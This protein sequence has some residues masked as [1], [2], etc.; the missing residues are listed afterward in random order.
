MES[1]KVVAKFLGET[2]GVTKDCLIH[3]TDTIDVTIL[4]LGKVIKIW[5]S[6]PEE[7]L[8]EETCKEIQAFM[9]AGKI[10]E[11][12]LNQWNAA[13]TAIVSLQCMAKAGA[14]FDDGVVTGAGKMF[15]ECEITEEEKVRLQN[16]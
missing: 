5:S 15:I 9:K 12:P 13:V 10:P 8:V 3:I 2:F 7:F 16:L 14:L 4:P 11:I 6:S 1:K